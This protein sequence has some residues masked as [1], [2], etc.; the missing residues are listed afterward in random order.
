MSA[1]SV[2][3]LPAVERSRGRLICRFNYQKAELAGDDEPVYGYRFDWVAIAPPLDRARLI[4]AIIETRYSKADELAKI[5]NRE[6]DAKG[7]SEYDDYQEFRIQAK[8]WADTVM[9]EADGGL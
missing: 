5:N 1:E 2:E 8:K 3:K 7:M 6:V 9:A 4:D